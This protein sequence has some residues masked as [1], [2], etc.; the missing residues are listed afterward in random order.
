M[1]FLIL[2]FFIY[3]LQSKIPYCL[4]FTNSTEI[5][6]KKCQSEYILLPNKTCQFK[7]IL[8]C[9]Q[10]D[11]KTQ[12][13]KKCIDGFYKDFITLECKEGNKYC[14]Y[15]DYETGKCSECAEGYTKGTS[16]CLNCKEINKFCL[17][18]EENDCLN[19]KLCTAGTVMTENKQ[20]KR[21][22]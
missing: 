3:Q 14:L 21:H 1:L 17:E 20:R 16:K 15:Y 19:C 11:S 2:F 18:T 6:C 13:C 8:N 12:E 9:E 10:F 4:E 7:R 5:E 22:N